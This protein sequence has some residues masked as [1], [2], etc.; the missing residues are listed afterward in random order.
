MNR[1][2]GS[3]QYN[4]QGR[5]VIVTGIGGGIGLAIAR[6]F[7]DSGARVF[8]FD[9]NTDAALPYSEVIEAIK[10][11]V[12]DFCQVDKA[13]EAIADKCGGVDILVN[14]AA[15]QPIDSFKPLHE[16]DPA[17]LKR[18]LEV[19]I[20][21]YNWPAKCCLPHMIKQQSGVIVNIA[22]AHAAHSSREVPGYGP[23]KAANRMQAI[24][25]AIEYARN[26]VRA[27]SISPGAIDTP[28][29]RAS[30]EMQGGEGALANRH[31]LG[32]LGQTEEI[33]A[34][35]LWACSPG[36]SFVTATNIDVD[37]GLGGFGAFAD[38]YTMPE[39]YTGPGRK[40]T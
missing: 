14:N 25:W 13:V 37:G 20:G 24:Q 34:A 9:L 22:S 38:P 32:R 2:V 7:A 35:V 6:A 8:G 30:L 15:I 21:G 39:K 33:A 16:M 23:T 10:L 3:V 17:L 31:P 29:V 28:M 27:L 18:M 5:V 4:N 11:D 1:P 12:S 40:N 26:G 36:A 19:N